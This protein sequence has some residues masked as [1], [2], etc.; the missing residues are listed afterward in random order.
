[1]LCALVRCCDDA[2]AAWPVTLRAATAS[3]ALIAVTE[4]IRRR[5]V[6]RDVVDMG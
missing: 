4:K 1:M 6:D 2:A 3:S 5:R